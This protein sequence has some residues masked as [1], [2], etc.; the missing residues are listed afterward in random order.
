MENRII[1]I[2]GT[3]NKI[4]RVKKN[5]VISVRNGLSRPSTSRVSASNETS[6]EAEAACS[7]HVTHVRNGAHTLA[8]VITPFEI[9]AIALINGRACIQLG[10]SS[11]N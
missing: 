5:G 1:N 10:D 9:T 2:R 3:L 4:E 6:E 11:Q 8:A 7:M